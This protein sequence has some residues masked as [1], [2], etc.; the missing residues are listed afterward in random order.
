MLREWLY[1][2][3]S[4][5]ALGNTSPSDLRQ[6]LGPRGAKSLPSRNILV[7]V[8]FSAVCG[9][10]LNHLILTAGTTM[11]QWWTTREAEEGLKCNDTPMD[12]VP[13]CWWLDIGILQLFKNPLI[14]NDLRWE[15][16]ELAMVETS[17]APRT[18]L[19]RSPIWKKFDKWIFSITP[20]SVLVTIMDSEGKSAAVHEDETNF[21]TNSQ[22][23][24]QILILLP[25]SYCLLI[26][27]WIKSP[28]SMHFGSESYWCAR[29]CGKSWY[30]MNHLCEN[31]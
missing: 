13:H 30:A 29:S 21:S 22:N 1:I 5:D 23:F 16:Q 18:G 19:K 12:G 10:I 25:L 17:L 6:F 24:Y 27:C 14:E 20:A 2:A 3:S 4:Q 8:G 26:Y 7:L 9:F 31:L 15:Q 11:T 28:I